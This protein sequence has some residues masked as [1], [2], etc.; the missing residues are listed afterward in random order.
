MK[1][2]ECLALD[3]EEGLEKKLVW[4]SYIYLWNYIVCL[5]EFITFL[6]PL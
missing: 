4:R 3:A 1:L 2:Y 5:F 6:K